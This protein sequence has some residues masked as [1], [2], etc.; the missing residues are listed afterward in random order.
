MISFTFS[1][2]LS[3]RTI[4]S[5]E[6]AVQNSSLKRSVRFV[7]KPVE[8]RMATDDRSVRL[9]FQRAV[10]DVFVLSTK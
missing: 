8:K 6:R 9:W 3:P 1:I 2:R 4:L 5:A 10:E 7:V